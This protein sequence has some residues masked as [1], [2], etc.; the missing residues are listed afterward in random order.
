MIDE[1]L[2]SPAF[3]LLGGG[4]TI[5][6]IL[7]YIASKRMGLVALPFWQMIVIIIGILIAS[8]FF[9]LRE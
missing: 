5:A 2:E 6:V 4:G 3:W 1:V 9:A 7:G 8:A